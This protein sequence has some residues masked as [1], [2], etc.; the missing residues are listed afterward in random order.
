MAGDSD[1]TLDLNYIFPHHRGR[2]VV[3]L[4]TNTTHLW[5]NI[6]NSEALATISP[7]EAFY[8]YA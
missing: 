4:Q 3:L 2:P 7:Y 8:H 6:G 1:P 5:S